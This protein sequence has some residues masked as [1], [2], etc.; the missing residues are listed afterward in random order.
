MLIQ[1]CKHSNTTNSTVGYQRCQP[2]E[3][4]K[5]EIFFRTSTPLTEFANPPPENFLFRLGP[6]PPPPS[7]FAEK[8]ESICQELQLVKYSSNR[9]LAFIWVTKE[10]LSSFC[11]QRTTCITQENRTR[12]RYTSIRSQ[13]IL[14]FWN[15]RSL[16]LSFLWATGPN[17]ILSG[18]FVHP[19]D[20]LYIRE[21]PG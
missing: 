21:T 4:S 13:M 19:G 5:L 18:S 20:W 7:N 10:K 12:N 11:L 6:P 2:L 1:R 9:T 8:P 15:I 14:K 17:F 16:N 3:I